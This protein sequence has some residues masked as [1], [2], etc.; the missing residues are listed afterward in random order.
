M[1]SEKKGGVTLRDALFQKLSEKI[2]VQKEAL[3]RMRAYF[4]E[5]AFDSECIEMDIED[6]VD[7]N[8]ATFVKNQ[9]AIETM[10]DFIRRI[11]VCSL[12]ADVT[13]VRC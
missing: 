8:I 9:R 13:C 4:E 6:V 3:H 2:K 10:A 11:T 1:L 5:N 12:Y 7:S